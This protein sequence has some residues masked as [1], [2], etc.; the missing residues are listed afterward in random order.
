MTEKNRKGRLFG[1][2][3]I[4]LV[5]F[6]VYGLLSWFFPGAPFVRVVTVPAIAL[7][8]WFAYLL[9]RPGILDP[10]RLRRQKVSKPFFC[11]GIAVFVPVFS[12]TTV[13]VGVPALIT[14][15]LAPNTEELAVISTKREGGS[16]RTC[17]HKLGLVGYETMFK[18]TFCVSE[19][20]WNEVNAGEQV[21]I[22]VRKDI[23]G[24][25]IFEIKK[26]GVSR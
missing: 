16:R 17:D 13:V 26:A 14:R 19:R 15:G 3:A 22:V 25:R 1:V 2:T 6:S 12:W 11:V 7:G 4:G 20:L 10:E 5:G 8:L 9:C 23:F 24:T 21:V 18:D